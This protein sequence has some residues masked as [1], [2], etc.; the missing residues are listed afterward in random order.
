MGHRRQF[1]NYAG[2]RLFGRAEAARLHRA[3]ME[4]Q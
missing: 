2:W 3:A 4:G 1:R